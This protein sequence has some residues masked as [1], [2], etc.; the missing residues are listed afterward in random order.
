MLRTV[1]CCFGMV[2][3]F[4]GADPVSAAA[5]IPP[6]QFQNLHAMIKPHVGE[7]RWAEVPWLTDLWEARKKAAAEGKPILVRSVNG[8]PLGCT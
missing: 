5:P 6:A 3:C 2:V 7:A 8:D 1:S 4:A